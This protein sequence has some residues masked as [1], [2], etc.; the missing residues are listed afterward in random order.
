MR[1]DTPAAPGSLLR[2]CLP[3][4]ALIL[5]AQSS[6][7]LTIAVADPAGGTIP[8]A[9]V[10]LLDAA[11]TTLCR[12]VTGLEGTFSCPGVPS[13]SFK[14]VVS[15]SGWKPHEAALS[16]RVGGPARFDVRLQPAT[17]H[18]AISVAEDAPLAAT[19]TSSATRTATRLLDIPQS[20]AVIPAQLLKQQAALSMQD[21]LKNSSGVSIHMGEGRRDQVYIRGFSALNEIGRASC[22]ERV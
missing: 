10:R 8:G 1:T 3:F 16:V 4:F 6:N 7:Q 13:G 9:E 19:D 21:A 12:G 11:S 15:S 22:R 17:P 20:V 14:L 5:S 18:F 2:A